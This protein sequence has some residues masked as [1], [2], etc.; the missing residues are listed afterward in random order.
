MRPGPASRRLPHPDPFA[1]V[2]APAPAPPASASGAPQRPI[3]VACRCPGRGRGRSVA[4]RAPPKLFSAAGHPIARAQQGTARAQL[5]KRLPDSPC[6]WVAMPPTAR[7]Q[8]GA[9][10]QSTRAQG[11]RARQGTGRPHLKGLPEGHLVVTHHHALLAQTR[12]DLLGRGKLV[13]V[14]ALAGAAGAVAVVRNSALG[15]RVVSCYPRGA[16][17]G[18]SL[19]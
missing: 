17:G 7:A 14:R 16:A 5:K 8:Q 6:C 9:R 13:G 4:R 10:A 19:L 15:M 2:M 18:T 11:H 1:E 12:Q 3:T